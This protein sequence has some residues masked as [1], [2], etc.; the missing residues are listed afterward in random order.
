VTADL[1]LLKATGENARR[2]V[3]RGP[4]TDWWREG[5]ERVRVIEAQPGGETQGSDR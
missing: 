2:S 4:L 5:L 3:E 1:D